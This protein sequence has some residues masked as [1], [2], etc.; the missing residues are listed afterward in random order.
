MGN[1]D[2]RQAFHG[3]LDLDLDIGAGVQVFKDLRVL[4]FHFHL[5]VQQ[6]APVGHAFGQVLQALLGDGA[7]L[8]GG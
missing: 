2:N 4:F 6:I 7:V 1:G 8:D 5:G 3:A